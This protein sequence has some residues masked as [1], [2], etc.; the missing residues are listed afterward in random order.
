MRSKIAKSTIEKWQSEGLSPSFDDI[1]LLNALGLKIE[2]AADSYQFSACPRVAYLGDWILREPTVG[3]RVWMDEMSQLLNNDFQ[4]HLYFVAWALNCSDN[5]LPQVDN[6]K[7][8]MDAVKKF[9]QEVLV[10]F[11]TTQ[12]LMA[13]DYALNGNDP[14]AGESYN[15]EEKSAKEEATVP[16][17]EIQSQARQLIVEAFTHGIAKDAADIVT[18][19]QLEGMIICAAMASGVDLIK[20]IKNNALGEFYTAAGRIHTRLEN[21]K[22]A[23]ENG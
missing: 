12:I 7:K 13:V 17:D 20:D 14:T 1:I 21:E 23:R 19:P 4:T 3:K 16:P 2:R 10:N 8:L 5:E 11:T 18:L 6:V 9:A 15:D 22:R